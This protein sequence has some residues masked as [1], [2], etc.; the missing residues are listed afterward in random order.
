MNFATSVEPRLDVALMDMALTQ[1]RYGRYQC[2]YTSCLGLS[3]WESL[4]SV[5]GTKVE[6]IKCFFFLKRRL[7]TILALYF[8]ILCSLSFADCNLQ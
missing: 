8:K 3:F 5:F 4:F 2:G 1:G 7:N 6:Q